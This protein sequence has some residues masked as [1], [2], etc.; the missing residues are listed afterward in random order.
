[1]NGTLDQQ[2]ST[3]TTF[4][5]SLSPAD[6]DN[7]DVLTRTLLA[8]LGRIDAVIN[9]ALLPSPVPVTTP[10][11][12][13]SQPEGGQPALAFRLTRAAV[14][15]LQQAGSGSVIHLVPEACLLPQSHD[16][17]ALV[18]GLTL[19]GLSRAIA[20][21]FAGTGLRSNAVAVAEECGAPETAAALAVML[22]SAAGADL[23]G[24]V[25]LAGA[26]E[27]HLFSQPRPIRTL[28][29]DGGWDLPSLANTLPRRWASAL[30]PLTEDVPVAPLPSPG[31]AGLAGKVAL[32]TGAGRGIGRAIALRL[33]AEGARV[34]VNDFGVSVSGETEAADPA[35]EVSAEIAVCGGEAL[36]DKGSVTDPDAVLAMVDAALRRFGRLDVVV[37]NAGILRPARFDSMTPAEWET[38][39][40]V[41]LRGSLR[42]SQAAAPHLARQG[43]AFVH[44]TSATGLIGS[45]GQANYAAAK[46]GIVGLSRA[47]AL[48]LQEQ[49]VRSNCVAPSSAS[50]MTTL[51]DGR[52]QT[53]LTPEAAEILRRARAAS[54]PEH[55][56]PLV[57]FLA[58]DAAAGITGQVI[59]ARGSEIYL[60]GGFRPLRS[61]Q[62]IPPWT[63]AALADRLPQAWKPSLIPLDRITDVFG[64][65]PF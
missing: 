10:H 58:S 46:L 54:R 20:L 11:T 1:M 51:A 57:A 36:A 55:M 5:L 59:G 18:Q 64:W 44:M 32:V 28:H 49:G 8:P 14:P 24:Q 9:I 43:G 65:I 15:F 2:D 48:D 3:G 39:L 30:V 63:P 45:T 61:L 47:L 23:S 60:Y 31:L 13:F 25:L 17:L 7:P 37:N 22:A 50:R 41:H 40:D 27:V 62:S 16:A 35:E 52:R 56:A 38:V 6:W 34:V 26:R 19:V 21:D 12:H 29:H 53:E 42:L 33:A 4:P